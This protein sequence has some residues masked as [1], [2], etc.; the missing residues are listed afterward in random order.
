M[1]IE[2]RRPLIEKIETL[3]GSKLICYLTSLRPGAVG[4]M[5]DD[6]VREFIDHLQRL[7][8]QPIE[9]LDLFIVSNGGDSALPWRLIPMFREYAK[10]V[11]VL[12][13][14]RAYSAATLMALGANEIV[15]HRFGVMGPIDPTV[16]NK[17]DPIDT[18]SNRKLGI[19][20]ENA[21]AYGS[22]IK[23]KIGMKHEEDIIRK[24]G[25]LFTKNHP[26]VSNNEE[27]IISKS[28]IIA[29]KLLMLH[30]DGKEQEKLNAIIKA[31][32]SKLYFHGHPIN[33][34]EARRDLGLKVL[35]NTSKEIETA[36]WDLFIDFEEEMKF[37][38]HFDPISKM[39]RNVLPNMFVPGQFTELARTDEDV[40]WAMVESHQLS[41]RLDQTIR[42]MLIA[43]PQGQHSVN[44]HPLGQQWNQ[45]ESQPHQP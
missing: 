21:K 44:A 19:S 12:I 4:L 11:D 1:S 13:P 20:V 30:T 2:T 3:R 9:K 31:L 23:D 28:R 41:S 8:Q 14:Y 40:I 6:A 5:A 33:R 45:T 25:V 38:E 42:Y 39:A 36:M 32:V 17:F 43:D 15:M 35:E 24:T 16:I 10:S 22:F 18:T 37:R 34:V 29:R 27:N 26:L 7:P